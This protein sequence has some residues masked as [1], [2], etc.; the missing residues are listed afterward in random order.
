MD[1]ISK[2]RIEEF[3]KENEQEIV[4]LRSAVGKDDLMYTYYDSRATQLEI[5]NIQLESLIF[6]IQQD[7]IRETY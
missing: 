7:V 3:I 6:K 4:R 5:T 1:K 2:N